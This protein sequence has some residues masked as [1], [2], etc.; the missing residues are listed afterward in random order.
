MRQLVIQ[1]SFTPRNIDSLER[2][3]VEINR[4]PLVGA[5]EELRLAK[6][7]HKGD[8][9]AVQQLVQA[10]L[11]FVVSVAKQ[12]QYRG[13]S[14]SDLINEGNLGLLHSARRFDETRGFKFISYA[15]WWIRQGML[16][17][18]SEQGR[19]VR[20]PANQV[21]L[22]GRAQLAANRFE[23]EQERPPSAYELAESLGVRPAQLAAAGQANDRHD[24]LDAPNSNAE[25][26]TM[27]DSMATDGPASDFE[28]VHTQSL[29]I[30]LARC[31][32]TLADRERGI[33]CALFGIGM[34]SETANQVGER[35]GLSSE[36][37][38]QIKDKALGTLRKRSRTGLLRAFL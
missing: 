31:L 5:E 16:Q 36:R 15:V 22:S 23:Q 24:S 6:A 38:R 37:V 4:M 8:E 17:A 25:G 32:G 1:P 35:F 30:E 12:Y 27:L 34:P 3:L 28:L 7:I 33:L 13:L 2:Y 10:N 20:L 21:G 11:R 26:S 14:L 9:E 29:G 19:L 18:I